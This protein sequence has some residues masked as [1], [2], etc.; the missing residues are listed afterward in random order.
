[1]E[2]NY[3]V[4]L[5]DINKWKNKKYQEAFNSARFSE[6]DGKA[7]WSKTKRNILNKTEFIVLQLPDLT[8]Q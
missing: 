1:M 6:K 5:D 8:N 3:I 2:L 7:W 4:T